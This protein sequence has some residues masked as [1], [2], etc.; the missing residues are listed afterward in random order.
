[1]LSERDLGRVSWHGSLPIVAPHCTST[2]RSARQLLAPSPAL[3]L[4]APFQLELTSGHCYGKGL[5]CATGTCSTMH[6]ARTAGTP[7]VGV[8]SSGQIDA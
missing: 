2:R 1:M 5:D 3:S 7:G 6:S 8:F 4:S